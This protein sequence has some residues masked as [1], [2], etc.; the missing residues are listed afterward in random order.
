MSLGT[1]A[2]VDEWRAPLIGLSHS[3]HAEPEDHTER[4]VWLPPLSQARRDSGDGH[5]RKIHRSG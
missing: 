5:T 3:L 2:T 1:D 4:S